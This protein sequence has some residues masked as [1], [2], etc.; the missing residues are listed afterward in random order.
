[1]SAR[2][3]SAR[4]RP[5]IPRK[6]PGPAGGVRDINR[7]DNLRRL[8]D[9]GLA[10]F[11]AR[12]T[13]DVTIEEIVG[14]ARM[15]KGSFYRYVA[16]KTELVASIMAPVEAEVTQALDRCEH[17]LHEA[18]QDQLAVIYMQLAS[19]LSAVVGRHAPRVLLY[20]QEAR[21]PRGG[22]RAAIHA[23]A[24]LLTARAVSLTEVA[25]DHALIR[26]VDPRTTALAVTG[27]IE[28]LL[29]SYLRGTVTLAATDIPTVTGELVA[30]ILRGVRV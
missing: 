9:A 3:G 5:R 4:K 29:F 27:A 10:L 25:S 11:L 18:R 23:F 19:E 17:A 16:D 26:G 7:R 30:I 15:A 14:R 24:E 8:C 22:A 20:L 13:A 2:Q 21:A 1:M 6:R 28:A 12:G